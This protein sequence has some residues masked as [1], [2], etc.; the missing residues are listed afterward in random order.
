[1]IGTSTPAGAPPAGRFRTVRT[2]PAV[3]APH[4]PHG[5]GGGVRG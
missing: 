4:A 3:P 5:C 2:G 1:M